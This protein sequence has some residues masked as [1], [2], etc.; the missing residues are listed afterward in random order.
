MTSPTWTGDGRPGHDPVAE[1]MDILTH[2]EA[3]ARLYD[4]IDELRSEAERLTAAGQDGARLGTVQERI[5]LLE[6][7]VNR[8][9]PRNRVSPLH[10]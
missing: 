9:S 8:L 5:D 4:E 10:L 2:Q 6:R 7:T 3:A 1:D